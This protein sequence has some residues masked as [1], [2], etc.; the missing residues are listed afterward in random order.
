MA[1]QVTTV[2]FTQV[3]ANAV[4]SAGI[5]AAVDGDPRQILARA[6]APAA[7]AEIFIGRA[8]QVAF[9]GS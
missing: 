2:S 1:N 7:D 6:M 5:M 4:S 9:Q 3:P 8:V